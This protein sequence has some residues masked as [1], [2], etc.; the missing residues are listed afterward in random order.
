MAYR[1]LIADDEEMLVR[2]LRE[3]L[4]REGYVVSV[5]GDGAQAL[6]P[7]SFSPHG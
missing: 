7:S 4:E 2:V 5:A 1:I 3:H 6:A